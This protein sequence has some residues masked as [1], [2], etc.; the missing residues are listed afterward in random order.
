VD[1]AA[2]PDDA[3]QYNQYAWLI[4]NTEGNL[5]EAQKYSQKSLELMPDN[6]AFYDT[7][8]RVCYAKKD[9]DHAL[10]YQQRAAEL[11]PH[12]GLIAKQLELF[13]KA[14]EEHQK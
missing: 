6:A 10:K 7:L 9:Y 2:H 1:I 4:G 14:R 13:R 8:A 5:D 11:E 12:S 3:S